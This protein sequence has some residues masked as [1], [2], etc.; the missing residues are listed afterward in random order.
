MIQHYA[1]YVVNLEQALEDIEEILAIVNPVAAIRN[2]AKSKEVLKEQKRLA[3]EI[4]VRLTCGR[5]A[6]AEASPF[7]ETGRTGRHERSTRPVHLPQST[8]SAAFK[9][10]TALSEPVIPVS[11]SPPAIAYCSLM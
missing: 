11:L 3:R 7:T 5:R 4:M 9:V 1:T 8:I 10:S 2:R 6:V